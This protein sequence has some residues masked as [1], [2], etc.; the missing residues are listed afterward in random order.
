MLHPT[1]RKFLSIRRL[2]GI[3]INKVGR[4]ILKVAI[5][6]STIIKIIQ[7]ANKQNNEKDRANGKI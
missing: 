3:K 2:N 5:I 4:E 6:R 1:K 7:T